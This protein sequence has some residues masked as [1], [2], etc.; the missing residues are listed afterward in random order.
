MA[1]AIRCT[2]CDR[3]ALLEDEARRQCHRSR[4]G[5]GQVVHRSVDREVADAAACEEQWRNDV[6]V[7]GEGQPPAEQVQHGAVLEEF[8]HGIAK[9]FEEDRVDEGGR[10]LA[11]RAVGQGD[12]FLTDL[13]TPASGLVDPVQYR[14]L[15]V[16]PGG[17]L[18]DAHRRPPAGCETSVSVSS[19]TWERWKRPK[20]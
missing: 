12:A 7:G 17:G 5:H 3:E 14:L 16:G 2:S 6:P 18:V 10:C 1:A 9:G 13:G 20:L 15:A 8:E 19:R 4:A 11:A